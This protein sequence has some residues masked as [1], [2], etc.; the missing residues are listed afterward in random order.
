MIQDVVLRPLIHIYLLRPLETS[1]QP[2][3]LGATRRAQSGSNQGSRAANLLIYRSYAL[4]T[5]PGPFVLCG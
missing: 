5:K 4:A 3:S 2:S 1:L